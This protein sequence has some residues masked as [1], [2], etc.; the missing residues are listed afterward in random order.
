MLL[1]PLLLK[2]FVKLIIWRLI[3]FYLMVSIEGMWDNEINIFNDVDMERGKIIFSHVVD[4]KCL[5]IN[6]VSHQIIT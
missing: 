1:L 3:I 6:Q 2:V 4:L 5:A